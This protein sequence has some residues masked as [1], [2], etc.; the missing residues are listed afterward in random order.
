MPAPTTTPEPR[1]RVVDAA[2]V[3]VAVRA[4]DRHLDTGP[5][6]PDADPPVW[7]RWARHVA[8]DVDLV[9]AVE[10]VSPSLADQLAKVVAGARLRPARYRRLG[11]AVL[12][13]RSRMT[14]ATPLGLFAGIAPA[15]FG[16]EHRLPDLDTARPTLRIATEWLDAALQILEDTPALVRRTSVVL[17]NT[18]FIRDD[19]LI[20][21]HARH[22]TRRP[23]S[24]AS[25]RAAPERDGQE[26]EPAAEVSV[27]RTAAVRLVHRLAATPIRAE[28]LFSAVGEKFPGTDPARITALLSSLVGTG[29]LRTDLRAPMT[30]TDPLGHLLDRLTAYDA[31]TVDTIT[32]LVDELRAVHRLIRA[33]LDHPDTRPRPRP[34]GTVVIAERMRRLT[35]VSR[36]LGIDLRFDGTL[37]LPDIVAREAETAATTLTRLALPGSS[38][39]RAYHHAFLERYG[40]GAVVPLTEVID[41]EAGLGWPNGYRDTHVNASTAPA[42]G[43]REA[44][45]L[46]LAW[47]AARDQATEIVLD[48]D[49]LTHLAGEPTGSSA[50]P[51]AHLELGFRVH[52][53]EHDTMTRGEFR[54]VVFTASRAAATMTGRFLD[55]LDPADLD[56][57]TAAYRA[58]PTTVADALPVQ[59]SCPPL[60]ASTHDIARTPAVL[61]HVLHLGEHPPSGADDSEPYQVPVTDLALHGDSRRLH[62]ISLSRRRAVHPHLLSA[63]ELTRRAHPL[64]RLLCDLEAGQTAL[65]G[66]FAWGAAR[67]LPFLPRVRHGRTILSPARWKLTTTDL[68][69]P[70]EPFTR[71]AGAVDAWRD[72]NHVPDTVLVG[73]GDRQLRLTLAD[74]HHLRLLRADLRRRDSL[75]LTEAPSTRELAWIKGRMHEIVV[76]LARDTPPV[77]VPAPRLRGTAVTRRD[78]AHL[79]G[80]GR[81][82][83]LKLY[84]H[85]DRHHTI[86]RDHLPDLLASWPTAPHW[87]FL[88][89]RDPDDH[90]RLRLA[91]ATSPTTDT[92]DTDWQAHALIRVGRWSADLR[93]RGLTGRMQL[94][95]YL[96]E[97]GRFGDG[98]LLTAAEAV[99][100]ADSA[101]VLHHTTTGVERDAAVAAALIDL[102]VT[103]LGDTTT[104]TRW[105]IDHLDHTTTPPL[106]R[107]TLGRA[108][109]L[110]GSSLGHPTTTPTPPTR[111]DDDL[112]GDRRRHALTAYATLRRSAGV[113]PDAVLPAL[114]H[115]HCVRSLGLDRDAE[116]LAHRLARAVALGHHIRTGNTV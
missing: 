47:T 84:A 31:H 116:R 16:P 99:F 57:M 20:L 36:P 35:P 45:S 25:T 17:D 40:P 23:A 44:R 115:L 51:P 110:A 75:T 63:V 11:E 80:H 65:P 89:Y 9:A 56:R 26:V 30:V 5:P 66:P 19:R 85:P 59:L 112:V 106:P 97:V 77:P 1:F 100:V 38:H 55:L 103:F 78:H 91:P 96:P 3:R 24:D 33:D 92:P 102:A 49:T 15:R 46:A 42:R 18:V 48:A 28:R 74:E 70:E 37:V 43:D 54:L 32:G 61:P 53:T 39:L 90:L 87:W 2:T 109:A 71:W 62:L 82:L 107:T 13:Y 8:D 50:P 14:R 86:L 81:W 58:L 111:H 114:L 113:D 94:D 68:P 60:Y 73:T 27:R 29:I 93:H 104:A 88:P 101:Y 67:H 4:A 6:P 105:L 12:R 41:T 64:A 7:Q 76:P 21:P 52:A 22:R 108:R 83:Y 72:R 10:L 79:P 69:C 95:T 34:Q 98:A